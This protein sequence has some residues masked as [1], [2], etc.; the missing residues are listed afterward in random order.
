MGNKIYISGQITG[1][2]YEEVKAKFKEAEDTLHAQGYKTV[3][4]LKNGIPTQASWEIHIAMDI[5]LLLGC[6]HVYMLPDWIYS[7]GA[8]LEKKIAE[9]TGKNIIYQEVP[10]YI[11]IK[12]AIAKGIGV[13][14][15]DII[16]PSR[17]RRNVYAR[18]IFSQYCRN[19]GATYKQIAKEIKHD[20][21]TVVYYIGKYRDD[22]EFNPEFKELVNSVQEEY[23]NINTPEGVLL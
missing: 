14:Y 15:I 22:M 7:K 4:P 2:P 19:K 23:A 20:H 16:G 5:I 9:F 21:S 18:M 17:E 6:K 3:N 12:E 1:L 13:S 8:T 11:E 10:A